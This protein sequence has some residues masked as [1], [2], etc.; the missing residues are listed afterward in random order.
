MWPSEPHPLD[1]PRQES[2]SQVA[3][4]RQDWAGTWDSACKVP[5]GASFHFISERPCPCPSHQRFGPGDTGTRLV[6][7]VCLPHPPPGHG[8]CQRRGPQTASRGTDRGSWCQTDT[9][10]VGRVAAAEAARLCDGHT[11]PHSP[12][13]APKRTRRRGARVHSPRWAPRDSHQIRVL[14]QP[15]ELN[16]SCKLTQIRMFSV[17]RDPVPHC[18]PF[19]LSPEPGGVGCKTQPCQFSLKATQ[20]H[21]ASPRR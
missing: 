8:A 13:W 1:D 16:L 18:L 3:R 17:T 20:A 6:Q 2:P 19:S 7:P 5:P 4:Q 9:S 12:P 14:R 10:R 11:R 15:W 21:A